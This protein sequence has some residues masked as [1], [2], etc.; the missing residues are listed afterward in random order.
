MCSPWKKKWKLVAQSCPTLCDLMDCSP[1]GSSVHGILQAKIL[2]WVANSFSRGSCSCSLVN[3]ETWILS[4]WPEFCTWVL[5]QFQTAQMPSIV[6]GKCQSLSCV[7]F[8]D[9]M[10]CSLPGSSLYGIFPGKNTGVGCHF[11][12]WR[13]FPTQGSNLGLLHYRQIL[14]LLSHLRS[15][16]KRARTCKE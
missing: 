4:P 13:I 8:Y 10:D 11:L 6:E 2:E 9:P 7:W 3:S 16:T 1:P 14:Y 15:P 5:L 12:L